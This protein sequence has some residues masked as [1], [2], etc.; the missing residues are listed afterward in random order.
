VLGVGD[1][2]LGAGCWVLG[3]GY[4]ALQEA[5]PPDYV[6]DFRQRVQVVLAQRQIIPDL[7]V[8]RTAPPSGAGAVLAPS[9]ADPATLIEAQPVEATDTRHA[10]NPGAAEP[11]GD[12]EMARDVF[13]PGTNGARS[14]ARLL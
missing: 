3:V 13:L 7:A 6:A 1:W 4:T 14:R 8:T 5:L 2:V 9:A 11:T 10:L 12:R